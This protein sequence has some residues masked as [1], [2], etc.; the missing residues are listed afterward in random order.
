MTSP[1][2]RLFYSIV[3]ESGCHVPQAHCAR[4]MDGVAQ[5]PPH[6]AQEPGSEEHGVP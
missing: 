5:S 6:C 3:Q 1:S 4:S 2:G